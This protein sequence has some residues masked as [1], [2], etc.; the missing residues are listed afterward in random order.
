MIFLFRLIILLASAFLILDL[1]FFAFFLKRKIDNETLE[2][3]IK[4]H[5]YIAKKIYASVRSA[6]LLITG[7][8]RGIERREYVELLLNDYGILED[9][10]IR[11][12]IES[13]VYDMKEGES[14]GTIE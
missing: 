12:L 5:D 6:E 7:E 8:N 4:K 2:T 9:A 1:V 10:Q 13:A 11:A 14:N 3:K